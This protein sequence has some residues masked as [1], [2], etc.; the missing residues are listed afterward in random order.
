MT[1]K[2]Y[3]VNV[4]VAS[5]V[6]VFIILL[7]GGL[8]YYNIRNDNKFKNVSVEG[9]VQYVGDA[10]I[11]VVDDDKKEYSVTTD[12]KYS[13]GDRVSVVI[14]DGDE[15]IEP[16]DEKDNVIVDEKIQ[17]DSRDILVEKS[18]DSID[19]ELK[20]VNTDNQ[21]DVVSYFENVRGDVVRYS[22]DKSLEKKIKDSFVLIVDFLFYDGTI[23]GKRFS[24]LSNK[25]K[26]SV[27]KIFFVI[28]SKIDEYF[29]GY[30][31]EISDVSGN[32]Y[33]NLKSKALSLYLDFTHQV[34]DNRDD[35]CSSAKEGLGELRKN[36]SIT[37]NFIKDISGVGLDKLKSWYEIWRD[38]E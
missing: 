15:R 9:V 22:E 21:G 14:R 17:E 33:D 10:Y 3:F 16:I 37:W 2:S 13:L 25:A 36:F 29:P 12:E 20:E 26:L 19:E 27:L 5:C 34:C 32:V 6:F 11:V 35:L 4:V 30:K 8:F 31:E 24:D 28:D 38:S 18:L 1:K 23:Q 7:L